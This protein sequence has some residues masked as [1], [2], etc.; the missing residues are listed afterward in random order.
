MAVRRLLNVAL[1]GIGGHIRIKLLTATNRKYLLV[2]ILENVDIIALFCELEAEGYVVIL[3]HRTNTTVKHVLINPPTPG[4]L[5][6]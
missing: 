2:K 6:S 1:H 4:G 3:Q 5:S